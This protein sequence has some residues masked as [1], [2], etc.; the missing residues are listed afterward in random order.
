MLIISAVNEWLASFEQKI[1]PLMNTKIVLDDAE[2]VRLGKKLP[3]EYPYCFN[4]YCGGDCI[5]WSNCLCSEY[6]Y[7]RYPFLFDL[8]VL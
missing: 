6:Y 1:L 5:F 7:Y 8:P 2:I 3:N 4:Y